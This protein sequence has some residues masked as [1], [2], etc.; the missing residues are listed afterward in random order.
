MK[1]YTRYT[2]GFI[3][4]A[5]II[6][7]CAEMQPEQ[8]TQSIECQSPIE[9]KID[10]SLSGG[11]AGVSQ[12]LSISSDGSM[13]KQDLRKGERF[14]STLSSE[15]LGKIAGMLAQACPFEGIRMNN[16][17]ADCFEYKLNVIMNSKRYSLE[18]NEISVPD[19]L[20]SLIEYLGS[21]VNK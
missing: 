9:W 20:S 21:F 12:S 7:A 1:K 6:S 3:L 11:F 17:C 4:L 19:N 13:I 16:R 8:P 10:F 14:E 2:F 18:T 5:L 15:E